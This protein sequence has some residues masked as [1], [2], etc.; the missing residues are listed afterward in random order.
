M[1]ALGR[2]GRRFVA[3]SSS[4]LDRETS[5][6]HPSPQGVGGF[7]DARVSLAARRSRPSRQCHRLVGIERPR[8][9]A[10]PE[11]AGA[12]GRRRRGWHRR[13][14]QP[15]VRYE[16]DVIDGPGPQLLFASRLE[17]TDQGT[18]DR[19]A[20]VGPH[21]QLHAGVNRNPSRR[22]GLRDWLSATRICLA[23]GDRGIGLYHWSTQVLLGV[24]HTLC[25]GS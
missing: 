18:H 25:A 2:R 1:Y 10:L 23:G 20:R 17:G 16:V 24:A 12:G 22:P 6:M 7:V 4:L 14:G 19:H 15:V 9:Y 21:P 3:T 8:G 11:D 13:L 5:V